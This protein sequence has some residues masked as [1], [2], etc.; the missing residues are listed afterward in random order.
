MRPVSQLQTRK[1]STKEGKC[2]RE[3]REFERKKKMKNNLYEK[4][5]NLK[6]KKKKKIYA[7]ILGNLLAIK[8]K[9]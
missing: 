3:G 6:G 5:Q 1:T 8:Y 7:N 4:N 2:M 9:Q